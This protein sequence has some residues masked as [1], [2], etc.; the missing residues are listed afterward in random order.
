M[1]TS[2]IVRS[3]TSALKRVHVLQYNLY[4]MTRGIALIVSLVVVVLELA[5]RKH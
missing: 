4:L 1:L 5:Q 3:A 2:I